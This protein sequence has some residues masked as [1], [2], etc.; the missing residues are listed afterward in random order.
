MVKKEVYYKNVVLFIQHKQNL[1]TFKSIA[2]VKANISTLLRESAFK[3]YI[4]KLT[5]FDWNVL[6]ITQAWRARLIYYPN[7]LKFLQ[8]LL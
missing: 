6:T 1:V 2:L 7:A 5:E 4:S 3:W 8:A